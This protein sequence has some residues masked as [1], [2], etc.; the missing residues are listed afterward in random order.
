MQ[1]D[2]PDAALGTVL[3]A[4][5]SDFSNALGAVMYHA[6]EV[7]AKAKDMTPFL[8]A[9]EQ[10][11]SSLW[12]ENWYDGLTFCESGASLRISLTSL[13]GTWNALGLHL[14]EA[15]IQSAVETLA[16]HDINITNFIIDDNWQTV[17]PRGPYPGPQEDQGL[18]RFEAGSEAFSHG[19]K[20]TVS[21]IKETLPSV[22]R[23]MVW[24]AL[25]GYWGGISPTG[26]IAQQY[27][28][29]QVQVNAGQSDKTIIA[30]EDIVRFYDDF[31]RFLA[32]C[33]IDGV[34][35]E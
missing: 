9:Q 5:G 27:K 17:S 22:K 16:K 34:K 33:G 15:R 8:E 11:S 18:E 28:T 7:A 25:A 10:P 30:K 6:R 24:H 19:L 4:V 3:V 13:V 1:S 26:S 29:I 2:S 32:S 35:T 23:V 12:L 20:H 21:I 31:Y 14:T